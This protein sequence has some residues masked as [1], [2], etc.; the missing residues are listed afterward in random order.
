MLGRHFDIHVLGDA[1]QG[2]PPADAWLENNRF[3]K[4]GSLLNSQATDQGEEYG[5]R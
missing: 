3:K 1:S 2:I 5:P 4:F